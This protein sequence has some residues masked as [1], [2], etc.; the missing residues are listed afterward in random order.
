MPLPP[1]L[2]V[3]DMAGGWTPFGAVGGP[4]TA[5]L[6]SSAKET[7]VYRW[8]GY[9]FEANPFSH[10]FAV[11]EPPPDWPLTIGGFVKYNLPPQWTNE[12]VGALGSEGYSSSGWAPQTRDPVGIYRVKS[13]NKYAGSVLFP[14][15]GNPAKTG[16]PIASARDYNRYLLRD[17]FAYIAMTDEAVRETQWW[18]EHT[19]SDFSAGVK[20]VLTVLG[21]L[22]A[23]AAGGSLL[24]SWQA[25]HAATAGA[26]A[27]DAAP[28]ATEAQTAVG[29]G[30]VTGGKAVSGLFVSGVKVLAPLA[31]KVGLAKI[32]Q[33][34]KGGKQTAVGPPAGDFISRWWGLILVA[35][36]M[37]LGALFL[38]R[39]GG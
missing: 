18:A 14:L 25:G 23:A 29:T 19:E 17:K 22:G 8:S 28:T 5:K 36:F 3:Y 11:R 34:G 16:F 35:V 12:G 15:T 2:S 37:G 4:E 32:L 38:L 31:G 26:V 27:A 30:T 9:D 33:A 7:G 20:G 24:A 21:G 1:V 6:I 10:D 39:K 13:G